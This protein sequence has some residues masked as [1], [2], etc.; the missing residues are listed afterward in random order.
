MKEEILVL[1]WNGDSHDRADWLEQMA[2]QAGMAGQVDATRANGATIQGWQLGS[3]GVVQARM[4]GICLTPLR[5][6]AQAQH[7]EFLY[8]KILTQGRLS[9][10]QHG[11]TVTLA[12]GTAVLIDPAWAFEEDFGDGA[13][14]TVMRIPRQALRARG[15]QHALSRPVIPDVQRADQAAVR[16]FAL[17]VAGLGPGPSPALRRQLGEQCLDVLDVLLDDGRRRSMARGPEATLLRAKRIIARSVG[18]SSLTIGR[19]A[20]ELNVSSNYLGR[21]FKRDGTSVMRYV[22]AV[23]LE[24][25]ARLL[26][27]VPRRPMQIQEIAYRCG[28][29]SL[30]H[31]SRAYKQRF[32]MSPRAAVDAAARGTLTPA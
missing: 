31:F 23:R 24:H 28:Y 19:L 10:T 12:A 17:F 5:V 3:I 11:E 30:A 7:E 29:V 32:G 22:G 1:D 20:A 21:L 2:V 8:L 16:D 18:D 9:V 13:A 4:S 6:G 27:E 14:L 26:R 25:A 15:L